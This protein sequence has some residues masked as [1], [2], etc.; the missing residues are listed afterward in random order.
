MPSVTY[1]NQSA[2][3]WDF[4]A[5]L[6]Q[7]GNSHPVFSQHR[8]GENEPSQEHTESH[9]EP[10]LG[11]WGLGANFFGAQGMPHR[12][13]PENTSPFKNTAAPD[14]EAYDTE[15]GKEKSE[16]RHSEMKNNGEGPSGNSGIYTEGHARGRDRQ[17]RGDSDHCGPPR[18]NGPFGHCRPGSFRHSGPRHGPY[19]DARQ[20]NQ[21]RGPRGP[22]HGSDDEHRQA[23]QQCGLRGPHNPYRG[24]G[25]HG[26]RGAWGPWV[27][28][29]LFNNAGF[30]PATLAT[31]FW[32]QFADTNTNNN[33]TEDTQDLVPDADIFDTEFAY[34]VHISL[35]GAKKE[36]VGVDWDAEKS[37]LSVAGVIYRPGD[38]EFLKTLAMNERKV[39]PFERKLRLGT[40]ASPAH[41]DADSITAKLE[42]GI[43]RVEV[44]KL[45]TGYVEIRKVDI[46]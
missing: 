27:G 20:E 8:H 16:E 35:P 9:E 15:P 33:G 40:R 18:W 38:E 41:I 30:D 21:Q 34:V 26:R 25:G 32:N 24:T 28:T 3:F 5:S 10:A 13:P 4:L 7:Q 45:D 42:D 2:P 11:P 39:G 44:P 6:E 29:G 1:M 46:E 31:H 14:F 36:D 19:Y 17:G 22:H 23:N 12:G 43:L 37:E